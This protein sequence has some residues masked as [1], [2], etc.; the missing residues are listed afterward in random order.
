MTTVNRSDS[1]DIDLNGEELKIAQSSISFD[2]DVA[3]KAVQVLRSNSEFSSISMPVTFK[4]YDDE[5]D[6]LSCI[7]GMFEEY[8]VD[9]S[10]LIIDQLGALKLVA[11]IQHFE[12]VF[13]A[14][15]G[16]VQNINEGEM[17][18]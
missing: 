10:E 9:R 3:K 11:E 16:L 5:G 13:Y 17:S 7:D 6:E 2:F 18:C 4:M 14:Y 1:I 15:F 12:H 8:E